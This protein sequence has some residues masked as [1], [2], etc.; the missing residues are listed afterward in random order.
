MRIVIFKARRFIDKLIRLRDVMPRGVDIDLDLYAL[1]LFESLSTGIS[2]TD[3]LSIQRNGILIS[4]ES[5]LLAEGL[6]ITFESMD[7]LIHVL[8]EVINR[9]LKSMVLGE[10]IVTN[11]RISWETSSIYLEY[12]ETICCNEHS[13]NPCIKRGAA[14][15]SVSRRSFQR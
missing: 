1:Y 5:D 13:R 4:S 14:S 2:P 15:K 11:I 7:C 3:Y 9:N 10:Y 12:H 6:E 8:E